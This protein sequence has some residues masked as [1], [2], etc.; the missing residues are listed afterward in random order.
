[1]QLKHITA[2]AHSI[3]NEGSKPNPVVTWVL[4]INERTKPDLIP[5]RFKLAGMPHVEAIIVFPKLMNGQSPI[6]LP[7]SKSA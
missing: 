1:M 2:Q 7:P 4:R 5:T 3:I 6:P